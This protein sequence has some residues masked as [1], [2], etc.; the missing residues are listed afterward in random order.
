MNFEQLSVPGSSVNRGGSGVLLAS[1]RGGPYERAMIIVAAY[2]DNIWR[3]LHGPISAWTLFG[4][5][6]NGMFTSRFV[7]QWYTS[8]R[9][10]QSVIPKNFW[11]L[12]LVGGVMQLIYAV[13]IAKIPVILG[14]LLTPVIA[15]RN[16]MLIS[17]KNQPP[18]PPSGSPPLPN[19]GPTADTDPSP[20]SERQEV[21][22][23]AVR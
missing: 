14:Y 15:A 12:S 8:E 11:L 13:H 4:L 21:A 10:K 6:G 7:V 1:E 16:L 19:A 17:K 3:H 22:A 23:S 5:L 9:L 20:A 2:L 18:A